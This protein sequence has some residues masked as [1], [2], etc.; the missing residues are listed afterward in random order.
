M[1]FITWG[2]VVL[3][4]ILDLVSVPPSIAVVNQ[5]LGVAASAEEGHLPN[6][7]AVISKAAY[8]AMG[9]KHNNVMATHQ[10][11]SPIGQHNFLYS[12]TAAAWK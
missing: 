8:F 9:N 5:L 7:T 12:V 3:N 10:Q 6:R 2:G 1:T 11:A 4:F